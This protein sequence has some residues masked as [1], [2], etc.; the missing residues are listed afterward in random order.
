[1]YATLYVTPQV[2]QK[3]KRITNNITIFWFSVIMVVNNLTSSVILNN[4]QTS[5]G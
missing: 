1:M 5:P 2:C 3:I 4:L